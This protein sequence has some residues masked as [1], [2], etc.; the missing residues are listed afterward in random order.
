M[1]N[2]QKTVF[3]STLI[4]SAFLNGLQDFIRARAPKLVPIQEDG[5]SDRTLSPDSDDTVTFSKSHVLFGYDNVGSEFEIMVGDVVVGSETGNLGVVT[6]I[7]G[8]SVDVV[9][10][11]SKLISVDDT[12]S[13][14]G[15][16]ADAYA[17]GSMLRC[18]SQNTISSLAGRAFSIVGDGLSAYDG[19]IPSGFVSYYPQDTIEDVSDMW[20]SRLASET[21]MTL[22]KNASWDGSRVSWII[23]TTNDTKGKVAYTNE[24][25]SEILGNGARYPDFI[26]V[27][28][29]AQ[30]FHDS[31][32]IGTLD[33]DSDVPSVS[34][35]IRQ[36][37]PAYAAMLKNIIERYVYA[38]VFCCTLPQQTY[39]NVSTHP[40]KNS[41]GVPLA[42]YNEAII[43]V[44]NWFGCELI[45]LDVALN[46]A[47]EVGLRTDLSG[48][49][50][51]A[52]AVQHYMLQSASFRS[53]LHEPVIVQPDPPIVQ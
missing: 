25:R 38:K 3:N 24:R 46:A 29:G 5:G 8:N 52:R 43:D 34:G 6:E 37:K 17:T 44:A 23:G 36:F 18:I 9:S 42:A 12:L 26:I 4:T 13:I 51:I 11:G 22:V 10:I 45:R 48:M 21:G 1:E 2:W 49:Q 20:W 30:D 41:I 39:N 32:P 16:P 50:K 19:Y 14:V 33:I 28:I 35:E 47:C 53:S 31:V 15:A 27:F 40:I 7:D